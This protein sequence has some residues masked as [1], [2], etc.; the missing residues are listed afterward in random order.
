[1]LK[2]LVFYFDIDVII[3]SFMIFNTKENKILVLLTLNL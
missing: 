2:Y 3:I 1:M